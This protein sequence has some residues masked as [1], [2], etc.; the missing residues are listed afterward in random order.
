[1]NDGDKLNPKRTK[2][3]KRFAAEARWLEPE[4]PNGEIQ[5]YTI[6][7]WTMDTGN[8]T[9]V[10]S[11]INKVISNQLSYRFEDL[12]PNATYY[13]EV[14][15][16]TLV[17][18]G[19]PSQV[20]QF[21]T[22]RS[23]PPMRLL[24]AERDSIYEADMDLKQIV[25]PIIKSL[26]PSL[27]DYNFAENR[28]YF[29]EDGN[30]LKCSKLIHNDDDG[31]IVRPLRNHQAVQSGQSGNYTILAH[32]QQSI[33]S[34]TMD[35]LGRR[36]YISTVDFFRNHS[37]VWCYTEETQSTTIVL[38]IAGKYINTMRIDPYRS[39]LI[40]T[41][42]PIISKIPGRFNNQHQSTSFYMITAHRCRLAIN[43]SVCDEQYIDYFQSP[44]RDRLCNC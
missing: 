41:A 43:G 5:S 38:T 8:V 44:S 32:F 28:L 17:G 31:E 6:S 7:L 10:T 29:V 14:R 25:R 23:E 40:W 21:K 35:W 12:K 34:I 26:S 39:M 1:M 20:I 22:F 16:T 33:T 30:F 18:E 19:P 3:E 4:N 37:T 42:Q 24:L 13:F 15:A 27:M 2:P 9:K 36:L 11:I